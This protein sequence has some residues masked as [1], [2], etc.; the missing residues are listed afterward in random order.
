MA[1]A[2]KNR[3]ECAGEKMKKH[4]KKTHEKYFFL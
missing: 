3:N 4:A 1:A 2:K